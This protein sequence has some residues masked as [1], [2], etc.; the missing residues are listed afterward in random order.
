[1]DI[2]ALKTMNP[3]VWLIIGSALIITI[4]VLFNKAVK[5]A[6]K[7]AVIGVV[8][9]CVVYFLVQANVIVLPEFGK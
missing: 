2:E 6:L 8:L 1:M 3:M 4:A 5:F 9:F 7:L